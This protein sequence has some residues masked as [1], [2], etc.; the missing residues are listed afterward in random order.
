MVASRAYKYGDW[1][2]KIYHERDCILKVGDDADHELAWIGRPLEADGIAGMVALIT[3]A[4]STGPLSTESSST[5]PLSIENTALQAFLEA[6]V[7]GAPDPRDLVDG[8][9]LP[10]LDIGYAEFCETAADG[11]RHIAWTR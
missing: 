10:T 6:S 9:G 3:G 8:L 2:L 11:W 1:A 4:L 5:E 7:S